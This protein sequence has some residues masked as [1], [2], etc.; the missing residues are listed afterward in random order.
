MID[1]KKIFPSII[2]AGKYLFAILVA[3]TSFFAI[4]YKLFNNFWW[5]FALISTIYSTSWDLKMD[6]G[7]LQAGDSYPLRDKLSYKN[8]YFYYFVM[9]ANLFLRFM[10]VLTVSPDVVYKFIRPEFFLFIIYLMEVLRR[11]MWNFIRVEYKHI[12]ICKEFKVSLDVELP[13]KKNKNGDFILRNGPLV[14]VDNLNKRID[15][16]RQSQKLLIDKSLS[17]P[18]L[19]SSSELIPKISPRYGREYDNS[20]FRKKFDP[21]I[22]KVKNTTNEILSSGIAYL[23]K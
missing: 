3:I 22:T 16:I 4:N 18:S 15:K 23:K 20:D 11:G 2:N 6:F 12:E 9:A 13:L 1:S 5:L 8:K 14:E 21:Y 10:W 17:R 7:F 19:G